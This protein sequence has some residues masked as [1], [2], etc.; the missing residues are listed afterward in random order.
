MELQLLKDLIN[1]ST[2]Q[3]IKD[4]LQLLNQIFKLILNESRMKYLEKKRKNFYIK[5]EIRKGKK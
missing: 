2:I 5:E 3:E 1:S 4:K